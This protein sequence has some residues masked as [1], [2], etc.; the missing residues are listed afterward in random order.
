MVECRECSAR[1][2]DSS[3]FC[4]RCGAPLRREQTSA[5][6]TP[7]SD[8][9]RLDPV[10]VEAAPV[11]AAPD[12][13]ALLVEAADLMGNRRPE[14]AAAKC[15]EAIRLAPEMVAAY[16]ML[17][18][19]EEQRG[20]TMAA[21]GAYR[22][23]LQIDPGRSA[24]R[25]KLEL[26]YAGDQAH[27]PAPTRGGQGESGSWTHWAPLVA[28]LGGAL[29]V[30]VVLAAIIV[31]IHS[32]RVLGNAYKQSMASAEASLERRDY[33]GAV[34][35][36]EAAL[37]A[38]PDDNEATD[39]LAYV[40]RKLQAG[41][42]SLTAR[43]LTQRSALAPIVPSRGTNPF[44]PIPIG[45]QP[46]ARRDPREQAQT[47]SRPRST[48]PPVVDRNE[49]VR[50]TRVTPPTTDD[51]AVQFLNPL[52]DPGDDAGTPAADVGPPAATTDDEVTPPRGE[53]S[54]WV[55][56]SPP[57][58]AGG[59]G[60]TTSV[61]PTGSHASSAASLRDQADQLRAAGDCEGASAAYEQA[62]G[63]YQADTEKNPGV[64]EAN[65]ASIKACE[66]AR[67]LCENVQGQ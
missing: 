10:T 31:N 51:G 47:P 36:F 17:G 34:K 28:G 49:T 35:A 9:D 11:E 37:A 24:E 65:D 60:G 58:Q 5:A 45:P 13:E 53:I 33:T 14:E 25:E 3:T 52:D 15:R 26:L 27:E 30:M 18:M 41:R 12:P 4:V 19:A 66:R 55:S 7:G 50:G 8:T 48:P 46:D 54:I 21:A 61:A 63:E 62:I 20:N 56:E 39:G 42:S 59:T 40:Q 44:Q 67:N 32:G 2:S 16:S 23:V 1:N 57:A 38:R 43:S 6:A 29:L 64:R 22:R